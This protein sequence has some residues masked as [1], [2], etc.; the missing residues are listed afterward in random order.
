MSGHKRTTVSISESEYRRLHD[1]E[2]KSRFMEQHL[3]DLLNEAR[4]ENQAAIKNAMQEVES[5]QSTFL[6]LTRSLKDDLKAVEWA[7]SQ[8][9]VEKASEMTQRFEQ[10]QNALQADLQLEMDQFSRQ[11]KAEIA[12]ETIANQAEF[13][14]VHRQ[15][16]SLAEEQHR[17][18]ELA[19]S[20][21]QSA[22]LMDRFILENY[23]PELVDPNQMSHLETEL[24]QVFLNLEQEIP[25]AAIAAAQQVYNQYSRL[26]VDLENNSIQTA[27]SLQTVRQGLDDLLGRIESIR[28]V[29]ALDMEGNVM[30]FNVDVDFW[31]EGCLQNL[32]NQIRETRTALENREAWFDVEYHHR[33]LEIDL[34]AWQTMMDDLVFQ[35]RL[36]VLNSQIRINI[37]ELIVHA[38]REQGFQLQ[39]GNYLNDDMRDGFEALVQ[40]RDGSEVLIRVNPLPEQEGRA[41]VHLISLDQEIRTEAELTERAREVSQSLLH[42][43]LAVGNQPAAAPINAVEQPVPLF[44][45]RVMEPL[46]VGRANYG[47]R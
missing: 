46:P 27:L 41:D 2:M 18:Q 37:A 43:G 31:T 5:R 15:F 34:P 45:P 14:R 38:L 29:P 44:N 20:W 4:Q 25:E 33:I 11:L 26:R 23:P 35:A 30:E 28:V 40:S 24:R 21:A 19:L 1:A 6:T 7:A 13:D 17:K 32:A 36:C 8:A 39:G 22:A 42:F 47:Y 12:S 10:S 9:L 3:P 16:A